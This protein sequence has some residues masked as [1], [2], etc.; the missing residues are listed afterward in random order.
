MANKFFSLKFM[1]LNAFLCIELLVL[2]SGC[3]IPSINP[4]LANNQIGKII[5]GQTSVPNS[6][7]WMVSLR[8]RSSSNTLSQHFCGGTIIDQITVLTAAHCIYESPS[9]VV[10]VVG[11]HDLRSPPSQNIYTIQT[12]YIHPNYD[13]TRFNNDIAVIKL[14]RPITFSDKVSAVCLPQTNDSSVIFNKNVVI[15]G[16]GSTTGSQQSAPFFLQQAN[17]LVTISNSKCFLSGTFNTNSIYCAIESGLFPDTNACFGDSGGPLVFFDG[18]KWIIYGITSYVSVYL[19]RNCNPTLP[20]FY[21]SV[22]YFLSYIKN[23]YNPYNYGI[24]ISDKIPKA[25]I[26]LLNIIIFYALKF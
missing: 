14:A 21:T 26:V 9:R 18:Q 20:S 24:R 19:N 8:L 22:P 11:L 5:N 16:W 7:P 25:T 12:I 15:T 17:L 23:P 10:V 2:V 1:I 4:S 6:W 13:N 3:G